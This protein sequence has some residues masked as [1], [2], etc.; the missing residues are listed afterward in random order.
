MLRNLRFYQAAACLQL[1]NYALSHRMKNW[2]QK[3]LA[4][5]DEGNLELEE[6]RHEAA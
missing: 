5:L 4:M 2:E 3:A 1:A 6:G